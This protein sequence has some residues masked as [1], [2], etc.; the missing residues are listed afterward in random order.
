MNC[1][2]SQTYISIIGTVRRHDKISGLPDKAFDMMTAIIA[3][4][5]NHLSDFSAMALKKQLTTGGPSFIT[6]SFFLLL[7]SLLLL[8]CQRPSPPLPHLRIGHA[9]HDHHSP[10]YVAAMNPDYFKK[11]GGIYLREIMFQK[12]YELIGPQGPLA[13]VSIQQSPGGG[14]I[15]R[16]LAEHHFDIAFGGVP[17]ILKFIDQGEKLRIIAPVMTEGAG[18]LISN[19]IPV[20]NWHEFMVY[21]KQSERPVRIG[22]KMD[23]SV[24]NIIFE[25]A[26]MESDIKASKDLDDTK[27][28][29]IL[30]NLFGEK[31]LV[32]A[33]EQEMIDGFVVM[34]PYLALAESKGLGKVISLLKDLPAEESWAGTPCCAMAADDA[35]TQENSKVVASLITLMLR[36]NTFIS[37]EPET[38]AHLIAKWLGLP[39]EVE[40]KS[41]PTIQF[42]EDY[43]EQWEKNMLLWIKVMIEQGLLQD[44]I[45]KAYQSD[46][47]RNTIYNSD[48][49]RE[50]KENLS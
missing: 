1:S 48:V 26:L 27:A 34:Q 23:V 41:L 2:Y 15:I 44:R 50:A 42:L 25:Q 31:N 4:K 8:S 33:L 22:Y 14:E 45:R 21:I 20:T 10:L 18:V 43:N 19:K 47:I 29:I 11:N 36:A 16:K 38:S 40:Q 35:F 28:E 37:A 30:V 3:R 5:N 13:Q 9:P 49:Y 24:Q 46:S 12:E 6:N 39:A 7:F 17:A 32:P